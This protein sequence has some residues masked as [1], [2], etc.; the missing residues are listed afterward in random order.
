MGAALEVFADH[1]GRTCLLVQRAS[2]QVRLIPL[3]IAHGLRVVKDREEAFDQKFKKMEHYPPERAAFL[4]A[5]YSREIGATKEVMETLA[6]VAKFPKDW[7]ES[8]TN[9]QIPEGS[10]APTTASAPRI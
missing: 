2:G 6:K 10:A 4:Y 1:Q 7:A 8:A 9:I 5:R 3:D